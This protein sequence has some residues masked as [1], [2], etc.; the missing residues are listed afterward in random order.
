[1]KLLCR[2]SSSLANDSSLRSALCVVGPN[3]SIVSRTIIPDLHP[4]TMFANGTRSMKENLKHRRLDEQSLFGMTTEQLT[5]NYEEYTSLRTQQV[6]LEKELHDKS[7]SNSL[8]KDAKKLM[9]EQKKTLQRNIYSSEENYVVPLLRAP[10]F[11]DCKTPINQK[12]QLVY[13]NEV[14]KKINC[15]LRSHQE[16][17]DIEFEE[18]NSLN[19]FLKGR[20]PKTELDLLRKAQVFLQKDEFCDLIAPPDIVR[21]TVI[22]GCDPL[23]FGDPTRFL[24]LAKSSDFG[25]IKSGL[26]A[27]LVGAA[28]VPALVS[29]S[30]K[31]LLI[32]S[33]VLPLNLFCIGKQYRPLS[34]EMVDSPSLFT[35]QQ[36][37]CVGLLSLNADQESTETSFQLLQSKLRSFYDQLGLKYR[38]VYCGAEKLSLSESLRLEAQMWSPL[39]KSYVTVGSL[40]KFDDF[41]SRRLLLKYIDDEKQLKLHQIVGGTFID[42]Y[43]V[44]GCVLENE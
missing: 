20:L 9:K 4:F 29:F 16:S 21:S 2:L 33:N 1:M 44:I 12:H 36:S 31:N 40:S 39:S 7:M 43:K 35:T 38:L 28:S 8:S 18:G 11:L 13:T 30:V 24:S 10:N 23:A 19:V 15:S 25:D 6:L 5:K 37:S 32:K 34:C 42:A 26:G 3:A 41:I 14:E 17:E 27:H 22:E